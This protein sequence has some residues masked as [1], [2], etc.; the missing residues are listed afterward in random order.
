M[1]GHSG[2][3]TDSRGHSS[4]AVFSGSFVRSFVRSTGP[5]RTRRARRTCR[6]VTVGHSGRGTDSRGRS[7]R[8]GGAVVASSFVRSTGPRRTCRAC[9]I[10]D[11]RG[12]DSRRRSSRSSGAVVSGSV[13]R[14]T[15][16][17]RTCKTCR[18]CRGRSG[19][20]EGALIAMSVAVAAA[21]WWFP[22]RSIVRSFVR[23][24]H[25]GGERFPLQGLHDLQ[26]LQGLQGYRAGQ[27]QFFF[28]ALKNE[29]SWRVH[30]GA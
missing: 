10:M 22:V 18:V 1:V 26:D 19:T 5:R 2:R 14:S 17:R 25:A 13:A 11:G 23:L 3:G 15:G 24:G 20:A 12:T 27:L 28:C 9:R 8:S 7:S 16:P 21:G 29:S 4:G 30:P 6:D